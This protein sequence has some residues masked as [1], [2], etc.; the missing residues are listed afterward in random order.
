MKKIY[1]LARHFS[2]R[3][4][5]EMDSSRKSNPDWD[6]LFYEDDDNQEPWMLREYEKS[7]DYDPDF[8]DI[9]FFFRM[10][11]SIDDNDHYLKRSIKELSKTAFK[12]LTEMDKRVLIHLLEDNG[13]LKSEKYFIESSMPNEKTSPKDAYEVLKYII[14]SYNDHLS[15][16][17]SLNMGADKIGINYYKLARKDLLSVV[18]ELLDKDLGKLSDEELIPLSDIVHGV[19]H[20]TDEDQVQEVL[21]FLDRKTLNSQQEKAILLPVLDSLK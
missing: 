2:K 16:D 14:R 17:R 18:K 19:A 11:L 8:D 7:L 20:K 1:K 21:E 6:E 4:Q 15:Y 3:S 12:N 13:F 10:E 9:D 5:N